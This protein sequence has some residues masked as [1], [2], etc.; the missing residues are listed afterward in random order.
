MVEAPKAPPSSPPMPS[1]A[2]VPPPPASLGTL[3]AG[4][5]YPL[6]Q[7]AAPPVRLA[8][9]LVA[10]A[11]AATPLI[12]MASGKEFCRGAG[13]IGS[14]AALTSAGGQNL[15]GGALLQAAQDAAGPGVRRGGAADGRQARHP[16]RLSACGL[17][18]RGAGH[19]DRPASLGVGRPATSISR[20]SCHMLWGGKGA[21]AT[22]LLMTSP[23]SVHSH[24]VGVPP[25][26]RRAA[27]PKDTRQR[28][29]QVP[30]AAD[31][32]RHNLCCLLY[33]R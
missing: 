4:P 11:G 22:S 24:D 15:D 9:V 13:V 17:H 33:P 27:P 1:S 30:I 14:L 3:P 32:A 7:G 18:L 10:A 31:D 26:M 29:A 21:R 5:A 25:P 12:S 8:V 20:A 2:R 6:L 23:P 19:D 16:Y 28:G